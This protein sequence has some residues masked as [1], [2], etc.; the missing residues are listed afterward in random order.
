MRRGTSSVLATRSFTSRGVSY[1]CQNDEEALGD[2]VLSMGQIASIRVVVNRADLPD[3]VQ[4]REIGVAEN[5]AVVE[6]LR[7]EAS[8]RFEACSDT[9]TYELPGFSGWYVAQ[10]PIGLSKD[11]AVAM[12]V[13]ARR[14]FPFDAEEKRDVKAMANVLA[15]VTTK[16]LQDANR[17]RGLHLDD[18]VALVAERVM[19]TT[20]ETLS[21][22]YSWVVKLLGEEFGSDVAF[23]RRHNYVD[24]TS[25]LIGEWPVYPL[26]EGE[27]HP[28][29]VVTFDS[30]PVWA[31]TRDLKKPFFGD[32]VDLESF[33]DRLE[34]IA[35]VAGEVA[36]A[37]PLLM[38]DVTWGIIG[39]LHFEPHTWIPAEMQSLVSVASLLVQLQ[40][41]F[42]AA[43]DA[44]HDDLT[45][46]HNR[47][48]LLA[49]LDA[50]LERAEPLAVMV[51]DLDRF[52]VM[53]D[54]LGHAQ[55][56]A[57]LV[58]MAE[59]V[60]ANT[61]PSDFT[62]RLGGDEFVFVVGDS[63]GGEE[64]M[65]LARRLLASLSQP[66]RVGTQVVSHTASIGVAVAVPGM[67]SL[68]LLAAAD[69]AMYC[70][71]NAGG[72]Q[73]SLY[74]DELA[75]RVNARSQIEIELG[76]TVKANGL[77]LYYQP[78][79]DLRTGGIVGA[80]ALVRWDHPL[81][82]IVSAGDFIPVA[83]E[84]G[85]IVDIDRWVLAEACR[86]MA[87]WRDMSGRDDLI[88]RVNISPA[89][90]ARSDF[91]EEV[92]LVLLGSGLPTTSLCI[93]VTEHVIV[94][95]PQQSAA[96]L[97][98]LRSMGIT[99]AIDDFGTGF[100]SLAELKNLPADFLKLDIGFVQGIIDSRIDRAIVE[101]VIGLGESLNMGIVAE[102]VET[103][104]VADALIALGC[105]RAQGWLFYP[106]LRVSDFEALLGERRERRV[107]LVGVGGG[108]AERVSD[109]HEAHRP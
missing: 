49:E 70:S 13:V 76:E 41:R 104:V 10:A 73:A 42:E 2:V 101:A 30:D 21:E 84:T 106:A 14:D 27:V 48:A 5:E 39:F 107:A 58:T 31:A 35:G 81:R 63:G 50:R 7:A 83:E 109:Q 17:E 33:H 97:T 28:L 99:I 18:V 95:D 103:Q 60:F 25:D 56:D 12:V 9:V 26:E 65:G 92:L 102:G 91:V 23:L 8:R 32:D 51:I 78:E 44:S 4:V 77:E 38:G 55:G 108:N 6:A 87:A 20:E 53:N 67:G 43:Y 61:R 88:V 15:L 16:R 85:V 93:E 36:C 86:Q 82:G 69:V 98:K 59:R 37:I 74:N 71:K 80:E 54:F 11:S 57:L 52:K 46:M 75:S 96:T 24:E 1:E 64:A 79:V 68:D 89:S 66:T 100:A 105:D 94:A 45:G 72:N 47:R 90:L 3:C 29:G 22:T 40:A 19:N 62:G 34:Q